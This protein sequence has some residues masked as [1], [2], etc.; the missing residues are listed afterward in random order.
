VDAAE[1]LSRVIVDAYLS[2]NITMEEMR[3]NWIERN[4]DPL[5]DFTDACR[6]ELQQF[7]R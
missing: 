1:S 3:A 5:R 6:D 2:P 4:L 7:G